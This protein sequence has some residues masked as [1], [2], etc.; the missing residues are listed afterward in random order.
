MIIKGIEIRQGHEQ[1]LNVGDFLTWTSMTRR[2]ADR[3]K[4]KQEQQCDEVKWER[5]LLCLTLR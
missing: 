5:P 3:K 2:L 1:M 4:R